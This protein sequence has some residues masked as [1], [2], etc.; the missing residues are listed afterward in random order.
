MKT[1]NLNVSWIIKIINLHH[2]TYT[3]PQYDKIVQKILQN[4]VE[5]IIISMK[6]LIFV[7]ILIIRDIAPAEMQFWTAKNIRT[8]PRHLNIKHF[9]YLFEI[10][11]FKI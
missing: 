4:L 2:E 8:L 1:L 10:F 5:I 11:E 9:I 6:Q 3:Q 7:S